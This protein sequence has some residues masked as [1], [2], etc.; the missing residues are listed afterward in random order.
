MII[1][2]LSNKIKEHHKIRIKELIEKINDANI[3][4][5]VIIL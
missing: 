1:L 2:D 5:F 4:K 3:I